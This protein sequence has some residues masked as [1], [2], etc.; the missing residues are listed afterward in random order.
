MVNKDV[1]VKN[2]VQTKADCGSDCV[3][4]VCL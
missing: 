2:C 4:D 3:S 1:Y